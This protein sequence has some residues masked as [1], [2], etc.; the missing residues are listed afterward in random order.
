M[1]LYYVL[2]A[3]S[4]PEFIYI[5]SG[6]TPVCTVYQTQTVAKDEETQGHT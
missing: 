5:T 1:N 6:T 3:L 4:L 2:E